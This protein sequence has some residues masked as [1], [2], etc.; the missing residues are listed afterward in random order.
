MLAID[1]PLHN[2]LIEAGTDRSIYRC[3]PYDE[4]LEGRTIVYARKYPFTQRFYAWNIVSLLKFD[5][6]AKLGFLYSRQDRLRPLVASP[7]NGQWRSR[8]SN[9]DCLRYA[10]DRTPP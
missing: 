10:L 5:D 9:T 8:H 3:D 7:L 1:A 4:N 6:L 2:S